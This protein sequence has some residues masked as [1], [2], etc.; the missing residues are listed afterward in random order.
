MNKVAVLGAGA[1]GGWLAA[2]LAEAGAKV[3]IVA[4]G[5]TL[6]ALREHGLR[7]TRGEQQST[8]RVAAGSSSELGAQDL[9]IVATKAQD[10]TRAIPDIAPLLH[11][12][13]C[14]VSALN[15]IP[16]WFTQ[17]FNGPLNN[18][19]LESVDP[20]G[21]IAS[22]ISPE[23]ALGCVVHASVSRTAPGCIRIGKVDKLIVGEP[24]GSTSERVRWLS[25][26]FARAGVA[27]PI[28]SDIRL[29]TWAKLWGNMNMNPISALTR[30][31]TGRM[32]GDPEVR[33]LC[34]R[35]ME[36][37]AAVGQRI[38]LPFD[39]TPAQR[40]DVTRKLG[41]FRTSMLN[42]IESGAPLEYLPQLG[43]VVE[44]ARRAGVAAPYCESVL[45]LIRQL[46]ISNSG[47]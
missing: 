22:A 1:I 4:R 47:A 42:D 26:T 6:L 12:G 39:M 36:E 17:R 7:L 2:A 35:M 24:D 33:S 40:M 3:A 31:S 8:Y 5:A 29:D 10:V 46:S 30:A 20:G 16:W 45:G 27:T 13:T 37:M 34:L 11:A 14:V 23:R 25:D 41:D 38:G 15:G 28:S 43:A 18:V 21:A 19:T 9:V 32:L 44:V